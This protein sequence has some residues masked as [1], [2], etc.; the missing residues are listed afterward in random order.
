[1][2]AE[3][4]RHFVVR[5]DAEPDL[6]G[7]VGARMGSASASASSTGASTVSHPDPRRS[8]CVVM[9]ERISSSQA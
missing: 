1:M 3:V 7:K 8:W 6:V 4:A 2:V 5:H 9:R